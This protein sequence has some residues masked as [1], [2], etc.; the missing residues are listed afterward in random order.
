MDDLNR[1]Q[2]TEVPADAPLTPPRQS[3]KR[4]VDLHITPPEINKQVKRI[5]DELKAAYVKKGRY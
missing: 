4:A 5:K 1:A 3:R 2:P